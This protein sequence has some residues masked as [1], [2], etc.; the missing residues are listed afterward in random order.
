MGLLFPGAS[1]PLRTGCARTSDS[2]WLAFLGQAR[3]SAAQRI[4]FCAASAGTLTA[5]TLAA[6]RAVLV[7]V[8]LAGGGTKAKVQ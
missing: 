6:R 7:R 3:F 2:G 1:S 5:L 8:R 4:A